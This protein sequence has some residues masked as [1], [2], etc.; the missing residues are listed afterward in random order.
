[1]SNFKRTKMDEQFEQGLENLVETAWK[2]KKELAQIS[3]IIGPVAIF[4]LWTQQR[5]LLDQFLPTNEIERIAAI[6]FPRIILSLLFLALLLVIRGVIVAYWNRK[7]YEYTLVLHHSEDGISAENLH[8]MMR[9][10]HR[11]KRSPL[12]RLV[13]G[14]ER[15]SF[16]IHHREKDILFYIG[17]PKDRIGYLQTHLSSLYARVE[18]YPAENMVFPNRKSV[19]GRMAPKRKKKKEAHFSFSTYKSDQLPVIL[20]NLEPHTWIQIV[21]SPN[22]GRKLEKDIEKAQRDLKNKTDFRN[23][24]Y[25]DREELMSLDHRMSGNE[26][27]FDVAISLATQHYSKKRSGVTTLK[28]TASAIGSIT[29]DVNELRYKRWRYSVKPYPQMSPYKMVWTSSELANLVHMPHLGKEGLSAKF[30]KKIPHNAPGME[31]LPHNVLSNP[32]GFLIG[33][34]LHPF[35]KGREIRVMPRYLGEHWILTGENGSGKSVALNQILKSFVDRFLQEELSPGFTFIDPAKDTAQIILNYLMTREVWEKQAAER[36]NREPAFRVNWDKVKWI[37]YR[38]GNGNPVAYPPAM[39]ILYVLP[40]ESVDM[41]CDQIFKIIKDSFDPAVQTERLLKMSIKTLMADPG[42]EHT[43]LGIR[44]LI[45][46]PH[47]REGILERIEATGKYRDI[48]DFWEDE[49][50]KM[51][52]VSAISLMN[53]LDIF[54]SNPLLKRVFGQTG[55]DFNVRKWMDEG[56]IVLIDMRGMGEEELGLIAS[57]LTYLY[58]RIADT[59]D[60]KTTP[61]LHQLC[62]DEAPKV[63]AKILPFIARE[64]RKKGLSLGIICQSILDLPEDLYKAMTEVTGNLFVCKQGGRNAKFASSAFVLDGETK[65]QYSESTLR[66]LKKR[67]LAIKI[68]DN[69]EG[70]EKAYQTIIEVPPLNRH[71]ENGEVATYGNDVLIGQSNDWTDARAED[72]QGRNG[73]HE[74]EIDKAIE[75]YLYP[76]SAVDTQEE[77]SQEQKQPRQR[78][79]AFPLENDAKENEGEAGDLPLE[80]ETNSIIET[81]SEAVYEEAVKFVKEA[82][83]ASI[84]QLQRRFLIG[85]NQA[86]EIVERLEKEGIIPPYEPGEQLKEIENSSKTVR[87]PLDETNSSKD[88]ELSEDELQ[89]ELANTLADNLEPSSSED[90]NGTKENQERQRF[91]T[92]L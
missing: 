16:T 73:L 90:S 17:A 91:L 2:N 28:S 82:G 68:V 49:A 65:P 76:K 55:F 46:K 33:Y 13:R 56:N 35:V 57:Y 48:I 12:L 53:R 3:L 86:G 70:E 42:M 15:Y 85:Y 5:A 61:L 40:G 69:V 7:N 52:D 63:P 66:N 19:G 27:A 89:E 20:N 14:K 88:G 45:F 75:K 23:R 84:S 64:Q 22:N 54:Y 79:L 60:A 4:Y 41:A 59:R 44:P 50:D 77:L 71:L 92:F 8:Q 26:V 83:K 78:M 67:T 11:S 81:I 62:I 24:T 18:F 9:S 37:S 80:V 25:T 87:L 51:M 43:I 30:K 38:D 1:M 10:F 36:E 6:Y 74:V 34:Q 31:L 29:D 47:F 32:L 72:L 58:Y 39:N 21:F